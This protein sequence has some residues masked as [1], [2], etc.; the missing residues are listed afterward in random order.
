ML[1]KNKFVV[2]QGFIG[3]TEDGLTTTL[4]RGGSDYTAALLGNCLNAGYIEIWTDVDGVMTADPTRIPKAYSQ[5]DLSF[6]EAAELSYFG[7]KVLHPS[8]IIP[9]MEKNIPVMIKNTMNP[10]D[11]GTTITHESKSPGKVKSVAIKK[12]ITTVTIES[13]R[14]LLA[15]GFLERIFD[16]FA[17]HELSVD[18]V[19]TSEIS[20][21]CT[22][23]SR[24]HLDEVL[25]E[26]KT[27]ATVRS[28]ENMAIVSLIGEEIKGCPEFLNRAFAS[29][30]GIPVEMIS[31]GASNVNLSLVVQDDDADKLMASLHKTFFESEEGC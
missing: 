11:A 17:R 4:G 27:F 10:S 21:S 12:H 25:N 18:L 24:H 23:D 1:K 30:V 14:M 31:F 29:T 2:T 9:A 22:L 20:V 15:Y 5:R 19:T 13:S 16:V 3:K 28:S 8:T 7:A 26:L 6:K